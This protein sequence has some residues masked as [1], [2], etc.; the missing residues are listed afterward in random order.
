VN[1]NVEYWYRYDEMESTTGVRVY[2]TKY[3]VLK[4]TPCGVQ[5]DVWGFP[6]F[7]LARARKRFACPTDE[8]AR[9]S[10][11]ARKRRQIGILEAQLRRAKRGLHAM[12]QGKFEQHKV[13]PFDFGLV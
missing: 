11:M 6:R 4:H 13:F 3:R 12:E 1:D 8:E 7:V 9:E 10:Y 2:Q 5:L